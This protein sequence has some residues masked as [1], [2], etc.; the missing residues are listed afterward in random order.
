[1][2]YEKFNTCTTFNNCAQVLVTSWKAIEQNEM[3][4]FHRRKIKRLTRPCAHQIM[5]SLLK[6]GKIVD[7]YHS[8]AVL[9]EAVQRPKVFDQERRAGVFATPI[10]MTR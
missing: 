9:W 6:I 8:L 3:G 2:G 10:C 5:S 1:M 4:S 7:A